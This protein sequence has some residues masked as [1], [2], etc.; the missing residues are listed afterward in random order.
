MQIEYVTDP[1]KYWGGPNYQGARF[2]VYPDPNG[3]SKLKVTYNEQSQTYTIT[4]EKVTHQQISLA[5]RT[6]TLLDDRDINF[7]ADL[8][9]PE[10]ICNLGDNQVLPPNSIFLKNYTLDEVYLSATYTKVSDRK[11]FVSN[12]SIGDQDCIDGYDLRLITVGTDI[13]T[14]IDDLRNKQFLHSHDGSFG[15]PLINVDNL[16]GL[17]EEKP[18]SGIYGPASENWNKFPNYLHR[19]GWQENS[20]E[21]INGQNA[22]RGDLLMGVVDYDPLTNKSIS[23]TGETH[24]ILFGDTSVGL[25]RYAD[26]RFLIYNSSL[27]EINLISSGSIKNEALN[28]ELSSTNF[29]SFNL[30]ALLLEK[31]PVDNIAVLLGEAKSLNENDGIV[32]DNFTLDSENK[33]LLSTNI[34][35]TR[36]KINKNNINF[37]SNFPF[38]FTYDAEANHE[39]TVDGILY[40]YVDA[41]DIAD[42]IYTNGGFDVVVINGRAILTGIE[43]GADSFVNVF[44]EKE[45]SDKVVIKNFYI[46]QQYFSLFVFS[47]SLNCKYNFK[48]WKESV[49]GNETRIYSPAYNI[50]TNL[51][52]RGYRGFYLHIDR[53][54]CLDLN[55]DSFDSDYIYTHEFVVDIDFLSLG[56]GGNIATLWRNSRLPY[57]VLEYNSFG[58]TILTDEEAKLYIPN[59]N[60]ELRLPNGIDELLVT[61]SPL[62]SI[63]YKNLNNDDAGINIGEDYMYVDN[64]NVFIRVGRNIV[65]SGGENVVGVLEYDKLLIKEHI[66]DGQIFVE[67]KG[68]KVDNRKSTTDNFRRFRVQELPSS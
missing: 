18:P 68:F 32:F 64:G 1:S 25:K 35:T 66:H 10:W 57:V 46:E 23:N 61:A 34:K 42:A 31:K 59:H 54:S 53:G 67:V 37:A 50:D 21:D 13:T 56:T 41:F 43:N 7:N 26:G 2:N 30:G 28:I 19:D 15:E 6:T 58:A 63:K 51:H 49:F 5:D 24:R 27:G 11:I 47:E 45:P 40:K 65:N 62:E 14:S 9:L 48:L 55:Y 52:G 22:M 29:T 33:D 20:P 4:L 38:A 3:D 16:A 8:L 39:H 44:W 36:R 17:F 12:L 60:S